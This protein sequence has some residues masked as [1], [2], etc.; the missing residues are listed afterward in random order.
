[1]ISKVVSV[2]KFLVGTMTW[3]LMIFYF[4]WAIHYCIAVAGLSAV[5]IFVSDENGFGWGCSTC[6]FWL[7]EG[8]ESWANGARLLFGMMISFCC[9]WACCRFWLLFVFVG[10]EVL[11]MLW[12]EVIGLGTWNA[13]ISLLTLSLV[14]LYRIRTSFLESELAS[15]WTLGLYFFLVA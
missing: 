11:K 14:S 15:R 8:S 7:G 4:A 6:W 2:W 13:R 12:S 3:L 9:F 1:M 5:S 10:G